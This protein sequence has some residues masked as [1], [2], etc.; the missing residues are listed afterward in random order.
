MNQTGGLSA[1]LST[2]LFISELLLVE[3]FRN[4][5]V[6]ERRIREGAGYQT[7]RLV[8]I[9]HPLQYTL[10]TSFAE[11]PLWSRGYGRGFGS[12]DVIKGGGRTSVL[13]D[14]SIDWRG[15]VQIN[16]L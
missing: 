6:L 10:A 5:L 1:T 3:S 9:F 13:V 11:L 8:L 4:S 7:S 14:N 2:N 12:W 15:L 16:S